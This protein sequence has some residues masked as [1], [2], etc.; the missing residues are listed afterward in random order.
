MAVHFRIIR[1]DGC[2]GRAWDEYVEWL[3]GG[4]HID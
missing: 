2:F 1:E 4:I 3:E